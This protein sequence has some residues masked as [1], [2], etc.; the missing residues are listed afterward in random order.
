MTPS[1]STSNPT[2]SSVS[3]CERRQTTYSANTLVG[4]AVV[5]AIVMTTAPATRKAR[6]TTP[7]APSLDAEVIARPGETR[8]RPGETRSHPLLADPDR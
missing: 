6:R 1:S 8:S 4:L 3:S 5:E 7:K 2:A